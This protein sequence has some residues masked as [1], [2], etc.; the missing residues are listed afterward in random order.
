MK[1]TD[2]LPVEKWQ[3]FAKEIHEKYG[4]NANVYDEKG[5]I[6]HPNVGWANKICPLIKSNPQSVVICASAQQNMMNQAK[7]KRTPVLEECDAGFSKFV[8]PIFYKDDF[9][10][11]AG[12]CGFLLEKNKLETFYIAKLLGKPEKEIEELVSTV[13]TFS[14]EKIEEIIE[15]MK[16]KLENFLSRV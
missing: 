8:I 6:I 2:I 3:E 10:G 11:T 14:K 12:G 4:I 16:Q 9:L 13:N 5:F 1:L 7:E 15:Y